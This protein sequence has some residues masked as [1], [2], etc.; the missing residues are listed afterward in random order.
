MGF[1]GWAAACKPHITKYNGKHW[2]EWWKRMAHA[3]EPWSSGNLFLPDWQSDGRVWVWRMPEDSYVPDCTVSNV[4]FGG[5][6]I[7]VWGW[8]RPV[9]SSELIFL[10]LQHATI[11]WTMLCFQHLLDEFGVQLIEHLWDELKQR[12]WVYLISQMLYWMN[13]RAVHLLP[14]PRTQK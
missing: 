7:M 9:I 14:P 5:G 1:Y 4:K 8:A 6:G 13:E 11:F 12:L 2:M 3:T 10:M